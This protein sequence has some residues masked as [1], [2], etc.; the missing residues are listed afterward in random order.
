MS[1]NTP[2]ELPNCWQISWSAR[3]ERDHT[4]PTSPAAIWHELML[5]LFISCA[6]WLI[7]SMIFE[8][9]GQTV[10]IA[11][12]KAKPTALLAIDL[13]S[14]MIRN[15]DRNQVGEPLADTRRRWPGSIAEPH[16]L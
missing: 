12:L 10:S 5:W 2:V 6:F 11:S 8:H 1:E 16:D 13:S 3:S 14:A 7:S 4:E 15:S 9:S